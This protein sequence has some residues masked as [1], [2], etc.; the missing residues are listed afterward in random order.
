MMLSVSG[1]LSPLI[2]HIRQQKA[3]DSELNSSNYSKI[4]DSLQDVL[5]LSRDY[6]GGVVSKYI[7]NV[8]KCSIYNSNVVFTETQKKDYFLVQKHLSEY[9]ETCGSM[10]NVDDVD[11]HFHQLNSNNQNCDVDISIL[12]RDVYKSSTCSTNRDSW[13]TYTRY[14]SG[15]EK[16]TSDFQ[17]FNENVK[18]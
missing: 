14:L 7:V 6:D 13:A 9:P 2:F 8:E 17:D 16:I 11:I 3:Y 12:N 10:I 1:E 5:Q 15:L 4:K 18:N